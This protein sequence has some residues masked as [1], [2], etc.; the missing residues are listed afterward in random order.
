MTGT[1]IGPLPRPE[2]RRR[3]PL[4]SPRWVAP[5]RRAI[6]ARNG[7]MKIKRRP[8]RPAR[9]AHSPSCLLQLFSYVVQRIPGGGPAAKRAPA[10]MAVRERKAFIFRL[11]SL[12]P[13]RQQIP[14]RWRFHGTYQQEYGMRFTDIRSH[15]SFTLTLTLTHDR[16]PP[17]PQLTRVTAIVLEGQSSLSASC[18]NPLHCAKSLRAPHAQPHARPGRG[19]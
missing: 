17:G 11:R 2:S 8:R 7:W 5:S 9:R 19:I 13:R 15:R 16:I 10:I 12:R 3:L 18:K 4:P 14:D 1:P 6:A